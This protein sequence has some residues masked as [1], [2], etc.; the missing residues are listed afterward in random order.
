MDVQNVDGQVCAAGHCRRGQR[1]PRHWI[2]DST[3]GCEDTTQAEEKREEEG[4]TERN[5]YEL[6]ITQTAPLCGAKGVRIEEEPGK[7]ERKGVALTL[8][9]L[10]LIPESILLD[11][12]LCSPQQ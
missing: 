11:N 5:S 3:A 7:G 1:L 2:R 12:K 4:A 8:A 9:F 6:T 10:F